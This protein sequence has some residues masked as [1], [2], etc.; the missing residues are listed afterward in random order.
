MKNVSSIPQNL[1]EGGA[2]SAQGVAR[3]C[4]MLLTFFKSASSLREG[5]VIR[6]KPA[7]SCSASRPRQGREQMKTITDASSKNVPVGSNPG[8]RNCPI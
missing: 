3:F 2:R 6:V 8:P 7:S 1:A 4:G 5:R